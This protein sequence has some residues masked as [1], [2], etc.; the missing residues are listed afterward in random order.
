MLLAA[1]GIAIVAALP[2][3][4]AAARGNDNKAMI[5]YFEASWN[6]IERRAPDVFVSG[7]GAMWLPPPSMASTG[8]V[9]Y[10]PF[11]RFNLGQPGSETMYGTESRF[12]SMIAELKMA[13]QDLYID[14][15]LNHNS[16]RTSNTQFIADGGWPGFYYPGS[17]PTP[18][19]DFNDGT[20]QS[21]NPNAPNYNLFTGDLVSLMDI[22]Q[23]TNFQYIRQPVGVNAANI[24]QGN[25]RNR[26]DPNNARFYPDRTLPGLTMINP[27][28]KGD[29]SSITVYPFNLTTP[30]NGTPISENA[31]GYLVRWCQW[32]LDVHGVDGFRLD[33]AKH[34]PVWF[35]NLYYDPV[36]HNRRVLPDGRRVTAFSFGESVESNAFVQNY[37]R[38]DGFGFRDSL[39]LNEAG[40]L[41]DL[42]SQRGFKSWQDILN[43]S[44]DTQDDGLNNGTQ[45]V[46]HVFSHDN[47]SVGSGS[48]APALPSFTNY[49][50]PEFAY[51]LLRSG[52]PK[53]YF[54]AREMHGRYTNRG[55]W[56]REGAPNSLG[57]GGD[58]S[59]RRLV[60]IRNQYARGGFFVLNGT[61]PVNTSLSDVLV[62][63]RSTG[64]ASS[65]LAGISDSFLN[66]FAS[67][68]VLTTFAPG[69]R[70]TELTGNAANAV[71]N[72]GGN[73]PQTLVVD[74]NRRVLLTIPHNKNT[75][76]VEHARGYVAYGPA[77]PAGSLAITQ[78]GALP[79]N[80]TVIAADDVSTPA[81]MRR[82]TPMQRITAGQ[83]EL[84]LN[85]TKADP[86]DSNF[87]DF[88][89]F[90]IDEGFR[91]FN[92]NGNFDMPI[93]GSVDAGYERFLTQTSPISGPGGTGTVGTYRQIIDTSLLSEGP[94]YISVIA[95]RRRTDGG[96]PM[97]NEWRTVIYVDRQTPAATLV[98]GVTPISS[99]S[100]EFRVVAADRTTNNVFIIPN[101]A[102]GVDPLTLCTPANQ[103]YQYDRFEWRRNV[104]N[105]PAGNN[106]VTVVN[107]EL[108]GNFTVQTYTNISVLLG[109]G[110]VNQDGVVTV[111][112][113]YSLNAIPLNTASGNALYS[114]AGDMNR[115][116][117]ND[118]GDRVALEQNA[119]RL[120]ETRNMRS[121]QR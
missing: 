82:N 4:P 54:N 29:G 115:N 41:R 6:S 52:V 118:S 80:P 58:L 3:T 43:S 60:A 111:D 65:L 103:A 87:D 83:F 9:G 106:S 95:Y 71:V 90:R 104:G 32:M 81:Y 116:G 113:L 53:V 89:I 50:M 39:D 20:T 77:V 68:S 88:A 7:Y 22:A 5:Q 96:Q 28:P 25:F 76:G 107:F 93:T 78:V 70:L 51:V 17:G 108:S 45:G 99:G 36:L 66:G 121:S 120:N 48:S 14:A 35:W 75:S 98:N 62:F 73:I 13:D 23:E 67:R 112:D 24:P 100:F 21:M 40:A 27:P 72:Q 18:F 1:C 37:V 15:V 117:L 49:G 31:T 12:R 102:N 97:Y 33:A 61:D 119:L 57:D 110:D 94:H 101:M 114:H 19:G 2:A 63:E 69:T 84:R 56:P 79:T 55:F 109:T 74:A 86:L 10:D 8:S 92:G 42:L 34:I 26:P 46:H 85:T 38:K 91:D 59:M 64:T 30:M 16:G 47:G 11:D 105:L 44:L